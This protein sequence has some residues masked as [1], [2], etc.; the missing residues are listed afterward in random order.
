MIFFTQ[1]QPRLVHAEEFV[2]SSSLKETATVTHIVYFTKTVAPIINPYVVSCKDKQ[3]TLINYVFSSQFQISM[4]TPN[5]STCRSRFIFDKNLPKSTLLH[6]DHSTEVT[7]FRQNWK[8]AEVMLFRPA[9]RC[10]QR[11]FAV[12]CLLH[13]R[14]D[15]MYY[16]VD[17]RSFCLLV[18]L[19]VCFCFCLFLLLF[20]YIKGAQHLWTLFWKTLCVSEKK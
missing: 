18:F 9:K 10:F 20:F 13:V 3:K 6:Q 8:V 7:Y 12:L 2:A 17:K 5:L 11:T 15:S 14:F 19:F 4:V 16:Y 1:A